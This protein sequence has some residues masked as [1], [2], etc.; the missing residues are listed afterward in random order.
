MSYSV[1]ELSSL[2]EIQQLQARYCRG[3]DRADADLVR[4]VYWPEAVDEHG[5]FR[6]TREEYVD[7]VIPVVRER[8][9][10]LQ[11]TLGQSHIELDG[12]LARCE[13]YFVQRSLRPDGN[14]Y[15]ATGRYLDRLE[16]R[17]GEWRILERLTVM[18]WFSPATPTDREYTAAAG[19]ASGRMD[20]TDP[21]YGG[22]GEPLV[23]LPG[24]RAS[25]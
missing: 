22:A 14:S 20:R 1:D 5:T 24:P 11:H 7:W 4:S 10:A 9:A 6:G 8:F 15:N 16:R 12:D 2:A 17:H 3:V 13:T 18:E 19:F 21:S 25:S 23:R